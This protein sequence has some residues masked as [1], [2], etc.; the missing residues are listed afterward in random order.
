MTLNGRIALVTG[1]AK[2]LG[3]EIA[4]A[5]GRAGADVA[6]SY[7]SSAA[8]AAK[9]EA[10]LT[11]LGRRAIALPCDVRSGTAVHGLVEQ[12]S[13]RL[14]P[15]DVL[16]ANAGVFSRTPLDE[17][18]EAAWDLHLDTNAKGSFLAAQEVAL[19]MRERGGGIIFIADVA[20]LRPWR[21]YVPYS[22]SKAAVVALTRALAIELAPEIRV[23]AVAPGPVLL[24]HDFDAAATERA[25][26]RTLLHRTG[27]PS[28]VAEAVLYLATAEY[29]TGV[30]L[31]VD[32]G[33]HLG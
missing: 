14:G 8:E 22:V 27:R 16:V 12:V 4:L 2:R 31:P 26:A 24:P 23:N 28:D 9:T 21:N 13:D 10:A 19:R 20:G 3:R 33:R 7:H 32:G 18:T 1:G 6:I 30:V 17:A 11:S 29:V 25:V 15:I 5:L